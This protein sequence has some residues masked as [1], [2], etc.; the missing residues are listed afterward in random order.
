LP[1][2]FFTR[3]PRGFFFFFSPFTEAWWKTIRRRPLR[4]TTTTFPSRR[5]F[6]SV[7]PAG[8]FHFRGFGRAPPLLVRPPTDDAL[9]AVFF[10]FSRVFL[11]ASSRHARG[12]RRALFFPP[13]TPQCLLSLGPREVGFISGEGAASRK[14]RHRPF[15]PTATLS[16]FRQ[17][18]TRLLPFG[19][20]RLFLR[21]PE[22]MIKV[23]SICRRPPSFPPVIAWS[24]SR[25]RPFFPRSR[26][27]CR[28]TS[29]FMLELTASKISF[30]S[31]WPLALGR[32]TLAKSDAWIAR[33]SSFA[34]SRSGPPPTRSFSDASSASSC[35]LR[36][37]VLFPTT[38]VHHSTSVPLGVDLFLRPVGKGLFPTRLS[39]SRGV[40]VLFTT[41]R[42]LSP[43]PR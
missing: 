1:D 7:R 31:R 17:D 40:D 13:P 30:P 36:A 10:F 25:R 43:L 8:P 34:S 20:E 37:A 24:P 11:L 23:V 38:Q 28:D 18:P 9:L 33:P 4:F 39:Q 5:A 22:T 6:F 41:P 14:F 16:F 29:L 26:R 2:C 42:C 27:L 3:T 35:F 21:L 19:Q 32:R 12:F 15:F